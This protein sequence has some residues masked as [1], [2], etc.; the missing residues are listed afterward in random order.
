MA[1]EQ[2]TAENHLDL[3]DRLRTFLVAQGWMADY[4]DAEAG[5]LVM[6]G[7][8]ANGTDEVY[9]GARCYG[10]ENEDAYGWELQGFTGY[11]AGREFLQPGRIESS[12]PL[13][14]LWN[15]ALPYR[16]VASG[17]RVVVVAQVSTVFTAAYLGLL[18]AYGSPGQYPYPLAVGGTGT[19]YGS[20]RWSAM[21]VDARQFV[22]PGAHHDDSDRSGLRVLFGFWVGL[23]NVARENEEPRLDRYVWPF[24]NQYRYSSSRSGGIIN[25]VQALDG[26][27]VLTPLI[28]GITTPSRETFGEL[29]GCFHV[30]GQG[31][32]AGDLVTVGDTAHLVVPN[33]NRAGRADYWALALE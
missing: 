32:A 33:L 25:L 6:H 11:A 9:V 15:T 8:G 10:D 18:K 28:V 3:L 26:T 1:T 20:R 14:P 17:R 12:P 16:F 27:C 4:W 24:S 5:V 2:G 19:G 22:D 7:P 23:R 30:S 13:L 31:L 29:E 21:G